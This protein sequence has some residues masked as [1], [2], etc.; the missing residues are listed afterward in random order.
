MSTEQVGQMIEISYNI[1][2]VEE[3]DDK[4]NVIKKN[5]RVKKLVAVLDIKNPTQVYNEKGKLIK[6]KC[7][8][9]I[10]DEGEITINFG[11]EQMKELL[12]QK[13]NQPPNL[14]GFKLKNHNKNVKNCRRN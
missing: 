14:I 4:I 12:T 5:L 2:I 7:R 3:K 1:D 13:T 6:N 11:Y 9:Y 10:K 8:V